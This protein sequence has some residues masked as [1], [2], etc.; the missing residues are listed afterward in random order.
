MSEIQPT[1]FSKHMIKRQM[2]NISN[3]SGRKKKQKITLASVIS[4]ILDTQKA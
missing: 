3:I 4:F 2:F 1:H